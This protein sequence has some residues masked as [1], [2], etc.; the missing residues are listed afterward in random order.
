[1]SYRLDFDHYEY[2]QRTKKGEFFLADDV[3][4][5]LL[6]IQHLYDCNE[7]RYEVDAAYNAINIILEKLD[8]L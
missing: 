5:V 6:D 2:M 3:K 8:L 7:K 4:Q 1:M